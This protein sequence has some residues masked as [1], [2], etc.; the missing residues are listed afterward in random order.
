MATV[1]LARDL[2]PERWIALKVLRPEVAGALGAD[3]F[4]KEIGLAA[5]LQHIVHRDIKPE[6]I[7]L[8]GGPVRRPGPPGRPASSGGGAITARGTAMRE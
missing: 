5:R 6:S 4:L 1:Y 3:R 8:S 7:L 2:K